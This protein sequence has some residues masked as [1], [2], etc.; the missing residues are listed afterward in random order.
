MIRVGVAFSDLEAA[1]KHRTEI[2]FLS[3]L[4]LNA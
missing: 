3:V 2:G 1:S 4:S